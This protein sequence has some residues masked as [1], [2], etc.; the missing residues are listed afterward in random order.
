MFSWMQFIANFCN[1]I[2]KYNIKFAKNYIYVIYI[3]IL[4]IHIYIYISR[5]R[6][7]ERKR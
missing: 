6:E 3:Y 7:R 5:E 2:L 1:L 4:Y